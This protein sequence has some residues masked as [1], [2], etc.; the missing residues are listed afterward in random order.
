MP[1]MA[2]SSELTA[3]RFLSTK[4]P[5]CVSSAQLEPFRTLKH[6]EFGWVSWQAA[7]AALRNALSLQAGWDSYDAEPPSMSSVSTMLALVEY[8]KN[9]SLPGTYRVMPSSEGGM[10]LA[11]SQKD[12][13]A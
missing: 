13:L 7:I 9:R 6:A 10:A 8:F 11:F 4:D 1:T 2:V 3:M 5:A 12:R